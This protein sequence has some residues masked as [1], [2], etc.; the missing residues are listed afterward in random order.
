MNPEK[1]CIYL[2]I[3]AFLVGQ[4]VTCLAQWLQIPE[5]GIPISWLH[6]QKE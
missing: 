3:P 6:S 5:M 1:T 4:M 2:A